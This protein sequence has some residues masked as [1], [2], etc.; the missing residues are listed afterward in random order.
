MQLSSRS[1]GPTVSNLIIKSF[2]YTYVLPTAFFDAL[3]ITTHRSKQTLILSTPGGAVASLTTLACG[4]YSDHK[5]SPDYIISH[6]NFLK[7]NL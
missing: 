3:F 2:G 6:M 7:R 5:V 4:W 1:D